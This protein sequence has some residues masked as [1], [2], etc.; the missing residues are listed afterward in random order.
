MT[1]PQLQGRCL[2]GNVTYQCNGDPIV[3][4]L[5]HC[6]DCQRQTGSTFSIIVAVDR[7]QF[8]VEGET[9]ASFTTIGAEGGGERD[10]KFCSNCGS[11]IVTLLADNPALAIVKAGTLDDRSWLAPQVEVWCDSAQSWLD[12]DETRNRMPTGMR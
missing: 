6:E 11:P 5:C 7:S 3:T 8:Q 1:N 12:V 2:C 10:R 4:A 9:L